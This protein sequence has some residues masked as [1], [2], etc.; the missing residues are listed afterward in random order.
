ML[1]SMMKKEHMKTNER[2][3]QG[4]TLQLPRIFPKTI[5]SLRSLYNILRITIVYVFE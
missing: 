1:P 4:Q 2:C 3:S 5:I